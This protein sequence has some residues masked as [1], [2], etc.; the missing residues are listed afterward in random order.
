MVVKPRHES[1]SF[2]LKIV[3]NE[4][5]LD[6]AVDDI[7]KLYQ[8]EALVEEYVD[9]REFCVGILGNEHAVTLP[10]VEIAFGERELKL[11]T[12]DDKF[13]KS[14]AEPEKINPRPDQ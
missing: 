1:S 6:K 10:I 8:Q 9:G 14:L 7:V 3:H 11:N 4:V 13:H 5:E 2:G 12:W